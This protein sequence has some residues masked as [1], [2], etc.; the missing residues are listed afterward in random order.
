M[1]ATHAA[2]KVRGKKKNDLLGKID[3]EKKREQV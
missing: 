2:R 1:K 3:E